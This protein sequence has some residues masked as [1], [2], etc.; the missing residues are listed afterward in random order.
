MARIEDEDYNH[1]SGKGNQVVF[2]A[3]GQTSNAAYADTYGTTYTIDTTFTAGVPGAATLKTIYDG[4]DSGKQRL[5]HPQPGQ[6]RLECRWL[7]LPQ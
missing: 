2:N 1:A 6:P 7:R 3:T 4:D 5:R